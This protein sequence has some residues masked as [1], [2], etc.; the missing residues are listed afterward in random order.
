MPAFKTWCVAIVLGMA[1]SGCRHVVIE[2]QVPDGAEVIER[3]PP[4]ERVEVITV[5][6]SVEHVW[7]KGHWVWR[8]GDWE[9]VPGYWEGPRHGHRWIHGHWIRRGRGFIFIPGYW[10]RL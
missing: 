10:H 9:W 5:A 4:A 2:E 1:A 6:P 3:E 8:H 7:V